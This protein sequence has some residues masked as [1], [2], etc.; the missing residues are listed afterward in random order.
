MIIVINSTNKN[1]EIKSF[2]NL[3]NIHENFTKY[4]LVKDHLEVRLFAINESI[5]SHQLSKLKNNFD[6]INI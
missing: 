6:K 4:A 1:Q 3:D 5:S 2:E